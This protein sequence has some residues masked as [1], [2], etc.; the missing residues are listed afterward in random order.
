M[1]AS[2]SSFGSSAG[3]DCTCLPVDSRSWT[4]Q[5]QFIHFLYR[6]YCYV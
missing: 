4:W 1:K 2:S 6:S 3:D 5:K